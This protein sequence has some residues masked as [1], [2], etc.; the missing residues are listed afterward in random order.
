MFYLLIC[1][2]CPGA[3]EQDPLVF[4]SAEERGAWAAGHREALGHDRWWVKDLAEHF[5]PRNHAAEARCTNCPCDICGAHAVVVVSRT[6]PD[7]PE[8]VTAFCERHREKES[9]AP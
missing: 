9:V 7:G 1:R 6:G 8:P 5:G 4:G 3:L 2:E